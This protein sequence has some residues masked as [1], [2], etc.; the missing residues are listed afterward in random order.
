MTEKIVEWAAF[1]LWIAILVGF[2]LAF[3]L[4]LNSRVEGDDG[5]NSFGWIAFTVALIGLGVLA[6][7][8][9]P[10]LRRLVLKLFGR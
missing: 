4:A 6:W 2:G 3:L 9:T 8:V 1:V 7:I 10:Q 5:L